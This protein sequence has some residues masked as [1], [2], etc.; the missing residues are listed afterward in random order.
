MDMQQQIFGLYGVAQDQ[1]KAVQEALDSLAAEREKLAQMAGKFEKGVPA[2][3]KATEAAVKAAVAASLSGVAQ[4]ASGAFE[5]ASGALIRNLS[6]AA[7]AAQRAESDLSGAISSFRWKWAALAAAMT[8]G[9]IVAV[10]CSAWLVMTWNRAEIESLSQERQ[11]L[12]ADVVELRK[13]AEGWEKRAGLAD[14]RT[15]KDGKKERLCVR[16][17]TAASFGENRDYFVLHGY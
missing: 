17:S 11:A 3:Q 13:T 2:L 12:L 10:L 16:V 5:G 8:L 6:E 7:E 14:L 1:Q 9:G 4:A 15:C